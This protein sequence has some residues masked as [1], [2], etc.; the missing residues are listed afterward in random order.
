MEEKHIKKILDNMIKYYGYGLIEITNVEGL[1]SKWAII[2]DLGQKRRILVFSDNNKINKD[3]LTRYL[4]DQESS[5]NAEIITVSLLDSNLKGFGE[6]GNWSANLQQSGEKSIIIDL[7]E[8]YITYFD[9]SLNEVINEL[10]NVINSNR[11]QRQNRETSI[12][13][14]IL[15]GINI[16]VFLMTAYF[17][18]SIFDINNQVLVDFG[19]K[20]N[21]YIESG[22]YYRLLTCMF[23]HGGVIHIALNMYGLYSIGPLVER[24]YGRGKYLVIYFVTG[25]IASISSYVFS[26]GLSVGASGAIFG[27]LGSVLAYAFKER[28]NIGKDFFKSVLSVLVANLIIGLSIANIDNFAHIGGAVSGVIL[29]EIFLNFFRK[30]N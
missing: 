10:A 23:L 6:A 20:Y 5:Y 16:L 25:I 14:L 29:G 18:N 19:A 11:P 22:Q 3:D 24:L 15:I 1:L 4:Q 13:T 27:L 8:N 12:I 17:S 28:N 2:K 30:H 26:I 9:E 7:H 21:P